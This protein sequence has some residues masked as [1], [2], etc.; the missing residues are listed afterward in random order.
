MNKFNRLLIA[1]II[2]LIST[3]CT[4]PV[5]YNYNINYAA[6][7]ATITVTPKITS[8][9]ERKKIDINLLNGLH[10]NMPDSLVQK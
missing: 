5:V 4:S 7:N 9:P 10:L 1:L 3:G 8:Q 2:S 6:E